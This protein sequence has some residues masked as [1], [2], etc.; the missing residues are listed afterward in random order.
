MNVHIQLHLYSEPKTI[1][2]VWFWGLRGKGSSG[3]DL[4][5]FGLEFGEGVQVQG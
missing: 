5:G 2:H 3:V 4:C 1:S